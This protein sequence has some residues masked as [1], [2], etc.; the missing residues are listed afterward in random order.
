MKRS[1]YILI[2]VFALST[3]LL[4]ACGGG[5]TTSEE[6]EPPAPYKGMTNPLAWPA[7]FPALLARGYTQEDVGKVMGGNFHRILNAT[8]Q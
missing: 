7:I 1:I 3:L 6:P 8:W 2:A 4:A 5:G